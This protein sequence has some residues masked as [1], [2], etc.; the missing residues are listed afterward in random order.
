MRRQKAG[1]GDN[2]IAEEKDPAPVRH[3]QRRVARRSGSGVLDAPKGHAGEQSRLLQRRAGVQR[4]A[5]V[6][7]H[8]FESLAGEIRLAFERLDGLRQRGGAVV[9]V[10][11]DA[12]IGREG[13]NHGR[14]AAPCAEA[15]K[16]GLW[17][18]W[19][20][21]RKWREMR[22]ATRFAHAVFLCLAGR[23]CARTA[24]GS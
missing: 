23:V 21:I 22:I 24:K 13:L 10:D 18:C 15:C 12:E 9:G 7:D 19:S 8:D 6:H 20:H 14:C 17:E 2:V 5:V 4:A 11:Q 3:R 1:R 16:I